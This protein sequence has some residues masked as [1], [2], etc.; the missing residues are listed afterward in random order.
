L[1]VSVETVGNKVIEPFQS[2]IFTQLTNFCKYFTANHSLLKGL[3]QHGRAIYY[4]SSQ[5]AQVSLLVELSTIFSD[6]QEQQD[7]WQVI[8][9]QF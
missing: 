1:K 5:S 4:C 6:L 3:E 8:C 2:Y 9:H 7:T